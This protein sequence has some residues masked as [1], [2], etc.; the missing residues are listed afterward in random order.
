MEY[1]KYGDLSNYITDDTRADAK[2][3]TTQILEGLVVLHAE[4]IC[5]RDLKL[6]V[7]YLQ[8]PRSLM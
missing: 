3:I 4:G 1:I 5:H 7:R 8:F 6:Q 2:E